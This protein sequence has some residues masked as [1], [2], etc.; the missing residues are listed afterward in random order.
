[1]SG[2]EPSG[3]P[4]LLR[5]R[6]L[7]GALIGVVAAY[8]LT[9]NLPLLPSTLISS[10]ALAGAAPLSGRPQL[11]PILL[12]SLIGAVGGGLMGT[13][14]VLSRKL[15]TTAAASNL[16]Q[17]SMV[18]LLL[19]LAGL[20]GG[21]SLS[22]DAASE[23]RRHPR[24]LLRSASALTTGI[25]AVLVT[26]TFLHSGLDVARAFS[27][28]LSTSLTILVTSVVVPG[29]LGHLFDQGRLRRRLTSFTSHPSPPPADGPH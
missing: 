18:L 20:I 1:M 28:R 19:A 15:L 26:F 16:E 6:R 23:Q 3:T 4:P 2:T 29:W 7:L 12:W 13:A 11:R 24:D 10:L 9:R 22:R 17:R 25:F 5:P 21:I 8:A 14:V 27:S